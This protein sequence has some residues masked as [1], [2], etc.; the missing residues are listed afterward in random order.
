MA[1]ET[2]ARA[3]AAAVAVVMA[4][5]RRGHGTA[6]DCAAPHL[7]LFFQAITAL[8]TCS[9]HCSLHVALRSSYQAKGIV[10]LARLSGRA[11]AARVATV[12]L[13]LPLQH[14]LFHLW[15]LREQHSF[16]KEAA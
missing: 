7:L 15:C 4:D 5:G 1:Y 11:G 3:A 14:L 8:V 12:A 9:A 13:F 6:W 2:D 16:A 10:Q